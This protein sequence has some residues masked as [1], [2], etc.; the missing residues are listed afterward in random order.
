MLTIFESHC[1]ND[2]E[3]PAYGTDCPYHPLLFMHRLK[4][5]IHLSFSDH[6]NIKYVSK[7]TQN[8]F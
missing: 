1:L 5:Y 6:I 7:I 8:V 4:I 3:L 2:E